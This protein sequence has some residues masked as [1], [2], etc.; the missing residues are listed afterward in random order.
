MTV[1]GVREWRSSKIHHSKPPT[2]PI[3][4]T[5]SAAFQHAIALYY[6][7]FSFLMP[8]WLLL[9]Q[10]WPRT[11]L[12][13]FYCF[14]AIFSSLVLL[15]YRIASSQHSLG[16]A[17]FDRAAHF[18]LLLAFL[19]HKQIYWIKLQIIAVFP[20]SSALLLPPNRFDTQTEDWL[21]QYEKRKKNKRPANK[22]K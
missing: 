8:H 15:L 18:F 13:V 17:H 5:A 22:K 4:D 3:F 9:N 12:C 10:S 19:V 11:V 1:H 7:Q 2:I 6:I 14:L 21:R 20:L 16:F